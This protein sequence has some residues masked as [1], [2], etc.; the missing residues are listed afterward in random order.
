MPYAPVLFLWQCLER[1]HGDAAR[2]QDAVATELEQSD[3]RDE[4]APSEA[5]Q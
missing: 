1:A 2:L 3:H 4:P 5:V